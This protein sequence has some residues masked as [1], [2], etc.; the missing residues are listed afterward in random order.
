MV[1][2]HPT[3]AIYPGTFDPLTMGHVSLVRRALKLFD[4]VIVSIAQATPK[5]PVFTFEERVEMATAVFDDEPRI[6]VEGFKGLLVDYARSSNATAILRGMRAVS[7][8]DHEFQMALMNR[9]LDQ[10]I[11][12]V[13]LLTDFRWLYIS[14]TIVKE[15]VRSGG[16][17]TGLVPDIVWER[18]RERL[19][20]K[21]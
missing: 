10:N 17:I 21:A 18:M 13:F 9:R 8:F 12:T 16:D 20:P 19:G 4:R 7:D 1:V 11:E 2:Q 5:H 15:V 3:T 14:S 6:T